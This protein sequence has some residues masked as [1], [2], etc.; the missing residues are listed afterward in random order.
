MTMSESLAPPDPD[1]MDPGG[2]EPP[3]P[4]GRTRPSA[5]LRHYDPLRDRASRRAAA[6][7]KREHLDPRAASSDGDGYQVFSYLLA[8]M[9]VYG[10]IGWLV[11]HFTHLTLLFPIGMVAGLALGIVRVVLKHGRA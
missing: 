9:L 10:F 5:P 8:G 11:G 1:G 6:A 3:E 7:R 2:T 4:V